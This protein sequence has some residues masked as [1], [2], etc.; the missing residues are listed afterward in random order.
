MLAAEKKAIVQKK[1][2]FSVY[3]WH[4]AAGAR[5]ESFDC[6]VYARAALR[7]MS[8]KDDIMLKRIYIAEPWAGQTGEKKPV[9]TPGPG[10]RKK[11]VASK[12]RIARG[13]GIEL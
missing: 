10:K 1:N 11:Q 9:I 4:K 7:I 8:P 13:K 6:R 2:G 5:N 12:N 3:E